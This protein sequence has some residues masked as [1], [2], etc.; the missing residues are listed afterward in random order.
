MDMGISVIVYKNGSH[1]SDGTIPW[2]EFKYL[3]DAKNAQ[4]IIK[5]IVDGLF[6]LLNGN[7]YIDTLGIAEATEYNF[8]KDDKI[9][10]TSDPSENE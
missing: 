3:L 4:D 6:S 8:F 5:S 1:S 10:S 7:G 2:K 9:L